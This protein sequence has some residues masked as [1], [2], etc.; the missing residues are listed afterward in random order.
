M[1]HMLDASQQA[2]YWQELAQLEAESPNVIHK[3]AANLGSSA[4]NW[5]LFNILHIGLNLTTLQEIMPNQLAEALTKSPATMKRIRSEWEL[6]VVNFF[7]DRGRP[8]PDWPIYVDIQEELGIFGTSP[9]A[10]KLRKIKRSG[11]RKMGRMFQRISTMF[12]K[13]G[14]AAQ[15]SCYY[16]ALFWDKYELPSG[17]YSCINETITY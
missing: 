5:F 10:R 2:A 6:F 17:S 15:K 12:P 9:V 11:Q 4:E 13:W 16:H 7:T 8:L 3:T 14:W 1:P